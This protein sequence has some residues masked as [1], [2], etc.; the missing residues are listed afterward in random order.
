[1]PSER[2][3]KAINRAAISV[4]NRRAKELVEASGRQISAEDLFRMKQSLCERVRKHLKE[5]YVPG[6][7]SVRKIE[8]LSSS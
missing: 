7:G 2:A 8:K 4:T 5:G 6:R 1:M 3:M